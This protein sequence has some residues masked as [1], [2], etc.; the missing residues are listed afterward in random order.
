MRDAGGPGLANRGDVLLI[1]GDGQVMSHPLVADE[2]VIGRDPTC[3]LVIAHPAL[4]RRHALLRLGPPLTVQDLGSTNGTRVA[5]ARV[6]GG[7]PVELPPGDAFHIGPFSFMIARGSRTHESSL[8]S[9]GDPLRID[10]PTPD[11]ATPVLRDIAG[12]A[13]NVL[14]LG[15]TGVGKEVL[16]ETVHRL[17]GRDGPLMRINCAAL[18]E[19]LLESELFG[20][21]KGA[22]TGAIQNR[23]G[24]LE[25]AAGGT[26]FLD[27]VGELPLGIQAK[28]LRALESREVLRIGSTTPIQLDVRFV[29]AT[30]RD[31][32]AEVDAGRFRRDLF[33]RLDGITLRIPP[34]R[35]R[36]GMI[37]PLALRFLQGA[38]RLGGELPRLAPDVLTLFE[39]YPWP[40]N[41]RELKAAIERAAL[42]ARGG[43]I[44]RKHVTLAPVADPSPSAD[45]AGPAVAAADLAFL[46]E[47]QRAD[48][49][50]IVAALETNGG[51]QTR[52][53]RELGISRSTLVTRLQ[54]YR[55]PRPK[56]R[57]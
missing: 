7:A 57:P 43:E 56:E 37:A 41:V 52:A 45:S 22:F 51:N 55:I 14:V 50:R 39:G 11:C 17:S 10:D 49:A 1:A 15:E 27:E 34:L 9:G 21:T 20:H 40:G 5:G 19:S 33:F 8:Q 28:L 26:A 44:R 18:S 47:E 16:A 48:R 4:S 32:P 25:A 54:V 53:A 31:L 13:V 6:S 30:N 12:S 2:I 38:A 42:L 29:A 3:E 24:L 46:S 23:A 35:E 36:R